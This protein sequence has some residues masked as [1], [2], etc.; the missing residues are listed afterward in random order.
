[1][2]LDDPDGI[3]KEA[4]AKEVAMEIAGL[5]GS[6]IGAVA[7]FV[8]KLGVGA[9]SRLVSAIRGAARRKGMSRS[10]TMELATALFSMAMVSGAAAAVSMSKQVAQQDPSPQAI[11]WAS[12]NDLQEIVEQAPSIE[13]VDEDDDDPYAR[14]EKQFRAISRLTKERAM[15]LGVSESRYDEAV[16]YIRNLDEARAEQEA[17]PDPAIQRALEREKKIGELNALADEIRQTDDPNKA[18]ELREKHVRM[19]QEIADWK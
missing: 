5:L 3:L 19:Y 16:R 4:G 6:G 8:A 9:A 18:K 2:L 15:E 14:V 7:G 17:N 1:M 12:E 13:E 10:Q 11:Q